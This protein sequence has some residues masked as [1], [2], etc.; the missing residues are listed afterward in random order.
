M[1]EQ[2]EDPAEVPQSFRLDFRLRNLTALFI[3]N[4][5]I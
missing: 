3:S 5:M 2:R 1:K 4:E